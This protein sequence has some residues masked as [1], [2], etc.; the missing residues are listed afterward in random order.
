MQPSD[1]D[2]PQDRRVHIRMALRALDGSIVDSWSA[3][4]DLTLDDLERV[5]GKQREETLRR[6]HESGGRFFGSPSIG[7]D[8][9]APSA[10]DRAINDLELQSAQY[11]NEA[12]LQL[13]NR[14]MD[15]HNFGEPAA[16]TATAA[17][18][19]AS[20]KSAHHPT[21]VASAHVGELLGTF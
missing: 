4:T 3:P 9:S 13:F 17:A 5:R 11:R 19:A 1:S 8:A 10:E 6:M 16:A 18:A 20:S 7:V 12:R 21:A 2:M 15:G 14:V